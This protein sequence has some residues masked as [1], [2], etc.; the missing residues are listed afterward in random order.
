MPDLKE[1]F[2]FPTTRYQGSKRKILPWIYDSIKDLEFE[3]VLDAFGGTGSVSYLLKTMGKS[4]TY[5]DLLKFNYITGKALIENQN[6]KVTEDD[7]AFLLNF[8]EDDGDQK[9]IAKTFKD[10]YFT[11]KENKWLDNIINR[12][13]K[14][15]AANEYDAEIKQCMCFYAVYQASLR[16]R[17]FNLFHR[18][19]LYL[20]TNDVKRNFGNKTTWEKDFEEEFKFFIEEI[21]KSIFN[22]TAPCKS[23]NLSAFDIQSK[24]DLIYF[25]IPYLTQNR[26]NETTDYLKCY[27]FLEGISDYNNWSD[28][29]DFTSKNLRFKSKDAV[30]PFQ[31]RNIHNSIE[32]L[33]DKF[34]DSTLVFS[35]KIGGIPEVKEI[36][37]IMK[38]FKK[39]V[40]TKSKHY[41]Y[42]LNKQNGNAKFNREV[43]IIGI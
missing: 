42:A 5:N 12:I 31:K 19:N 26:K 23:I 1:D 22:S 32:Q 35:Y 37:A 24:Y 25:D 6:I 28:Q 40:F 20:R 15:S 33:F 3:T 43:L 18:K 8:D 11:D 13:S 29:I 27:H 16:K 4:V 39:N 36:E 41:K 2:F 17:P 30:N 9:F 38:G 21:N 34:K 14:L 7:I 10:F